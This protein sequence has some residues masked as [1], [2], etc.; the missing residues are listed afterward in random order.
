[1]NGESSKCKF[2]ENNY[3]CNRVSIEYSY[4]VNVSHKRNL[5]GC[6]NANFFS[7]V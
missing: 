1:M 6:L 3:D 2:S 7:N 4:N 5:I